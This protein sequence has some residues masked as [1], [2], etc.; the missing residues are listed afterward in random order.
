MGGAALRWLTDEMK[1]VQ[2]EISKEQEGEAT[3]LRRLNTQKADIGLLHK[4]LKPF[5]NRYDTDQ[6][7]A[8]NAGEVKMLLFDLN[9]KPTEKNVGT[10][11]QDQDKDHNRT[12]DFNE[13]VEALYTSYMRD[14]DELETLDTKADPR[15][16]PAYD[17]DQEEEEM[18][19]EFADLHPAEQQRAL[20]INSFKM[21]GFGTFLV[22]LFADPMVAVLSEWGNRLGVNA[23]YISFIISPLASNASELLAA[24]QYGQKKTKAGITTALSTLVGAA[25]MNNTFCLGIFLA[26]VYFQKLAWKFTA[27]TICC[28]LSQWVIGALTL[29]S[30]TQ[31]AKDSYVILAC[32]PL[33]LGGVWF[34]ENICLLD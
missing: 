2:D 31:T 16:I 25:C 5:F 29:K 21:M 23:F 30:K 8:L 11:I 34:L 7:G 3:Q 27:E 12:L 24:M 15:Y 33:C 32:Y 1:K 13:F 14:E 28:V 19:E 4:V 18:P 9:L 22:V 10:F 17:D 6:S 20:L 26:I